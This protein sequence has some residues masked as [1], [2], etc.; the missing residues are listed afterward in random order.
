MGAGEEK[1]VYGLCD[2]DNH[3]FALEIIN[4]RTYLNGRLIGGDYFFERHIEGLA[5]VKPNPDEIQPFTFTGLVKVR[6]YIY[7]YTWDGFQFDARRKSWLD[8]VLTAFLQGYFA[9][10]FQ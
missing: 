7:G 2:P 3:I 10:Q 1:A 8:R 9:G 6:E 4:E 5:Q